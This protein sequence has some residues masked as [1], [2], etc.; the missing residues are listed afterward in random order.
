MTKM[1]I[2]AAS[3]LLSLLLLL[4]CSTGLS[5]QQKRVSLVP[6]RLSPKKLFR[7]TTTT[8]PPPKTFGDSLSLEQP[9]HKGG[10][11]SSHVRY[12][13]NDP[14][15]EQQKTGWKALIQRIS[16]YASLLCVLDCTLLPLFT[17]LFPL[18]GAANSSLEWLHHAGHMVALG[19]VLPVGAL[20]TT[21]NF[22]THK[23]NELLA[24]SLVGLV[25]ILLANAP[26]LPHV[27]HLF[28]H[29]MTHRIINIVGCALL[30]TSNFLSHRLVHQNCDC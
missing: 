14:V 10:A 18:V 22:S 30:L 27:P 1:T 23:R 7:R 2:S 9:S 24:T 19:F 11:P 5:T 21:L 16:N 3:R 15:D 26:H 4:V 6:Q 28:H 29:G 25:M 12:R 17:I 8:A 20:T 13:F